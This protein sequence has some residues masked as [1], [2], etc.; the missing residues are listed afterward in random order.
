MPFQQKSARFLENH[1]EPRIASVLPSARHRAA[2]AIT[3][4]APGLRFFHHGQLEGFRIRIPVH[5]CRGPAELIDQHV[6]ALYETLLPII[7]SRTALE[8]SWSLRDCRPAWDR[9]ATNE[10]FV[11]QLMQHED[12]ALL[13]TVNNAPQQAQCFVQLPHE[14]LT[15][16]ECT[17]RDLLSDAVYT[18]STSDLKARGL[19][20][21]TPDW[22][23]HIFELGPS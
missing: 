13:V 7:H 2:A 10:H 3:F 11:C 9:N 14:I 8:G 6:K 17:F 1:D 15:G 16:N 19:Y 22:H 18:R 5:L 23:V 21:D 4:F 12:T 20:L